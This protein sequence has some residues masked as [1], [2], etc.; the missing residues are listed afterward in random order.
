MDKYVSQWKRQAT[1]NIQ[2]VGT[3]DSYVEEDISNFIV[4]DTES[5]NSESEEEEI[6]EVDDGESNLQGIASIQLPKRI[7]LQPKST[8]TNKSTISMKIKP[9][10]S[11]AN[12]KHCA[13]LDLTVSRSPMKKRSK[14]VENE[15][16]KAMFQRQLQIP[17][18]RPTSI[19]A[20]AA[21][22]SSSNVAAA[23]SVIAAVCPVPS[24]QPVSVGTASA[25]P[26]QRS[27]SAPSVPT[28]AVVVS[29]RKRKHLVLDDEDDDEFQRLVDS[30]DDADDILLLTKDEGRAAAQK[31][32][33]PTRQRN[34][35]MIGLIQA[36]TT[37]T[38]PFASQQF[39]RLSKLQ[40]QYASCSVTSKVSEQEVGGGGSQMESVVAV[41]SASSAS[42]GQSSSVPYATS[43]P[44]DMDALQSVPAFAP[45][46]FSRA[47][48]LHGEYMHM[49]MKH[50][51]WNRMRPVL[52][53]SLSGKLDA[54]GRA[55]HEQS[56]MMQ[57]QQSAL[58]D[59]SINELSYVNGIEFDA[60]GSLM[61][62]SSNNALLNLYDFDCVWMDGRRVEN[63]K[64]RYAWEAHKQK[65]KAEYEARNR[66]NSPPR[67]RLGW[68]L[69][70]PAPPIRTS[71]PCSTPS[72][73]LIQPIFSMDLQASTRIRASNREPAL[74]PLHSLKQID[75]HRWSPYNTNEMGISSKKN[76]QIFM[77][78]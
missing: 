36:V 10:P 47:C 77:S 73:L 5:S 63:D 7:K 44:R 76:N 49:S 61:S 15:K 46:H 31:K 29:S 11:A 14:L 50:L 64:R 55:P 6:E 69:N 41:G 78:V 18:T 34:R 53:W 20:H 71:T 65:Q 45:L 40:R 66:S 35:N 54:S 70:Q 52:D 9:T 21:A 72:H 60:T 23:S 62:A 74:P 38:T 8:S 30:I 57:H 59:R 27:V 37:A 4:P 75:A 28:S 22:A 2:L 42:C 58:M 48:M 39:A 16:A 17:S 24:S 25:P 32:R 19:A 68:Q 12:V 1:D 51:L 43:S 56:P 26:L 3:T 67:S 13:V 33:E